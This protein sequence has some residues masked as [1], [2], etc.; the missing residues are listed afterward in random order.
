M[1]FA[2]FQRDSQGRFQATGDLPQWWQRLD[3][4]HD[5]SDD[6]MAFAERHPFFQHFLADA[7]SF[8][9]LGNPG[10]LDSGV[11]EHSLG[12]E[13]VLYLHLHAVQS[14]DG[15]QILI[16][17]DLE[18]TGLRY[19]AHVQRGR[20]SHLQYLKETNLR[21]QLEIE[22]QR[23]TEAAERLDRVRMEFLANVSHELRTPVSA[24]LGLSE[25]LDGT[26]LTSD[27]R[28]LV[29][30]L[31]S[32]GRQLLRLVQDLLDTSSM[33]SGQLVIRT[34]PYQLHEIVADAESS[35]RKRAEAKGL[36]FQIDI[37]ASLGE[38]GL[39]DVTRIRQIVNN[40]L[41][42]A[43][44]FTTTG[45]ITFR[46]GLTPL[47][48]RR[49]QLDVEDSGAGIP[50]DLQGTIFEPFV[51]V[52]ASMHRQHGGAGLG[53]A[54]SAQLAK[55]MGGTI[56]VQSQPGCGSRFSV[57]LPWEQPAVSLARHPHASV[58]SPT[59]RH[60]GAPLRQAEPTAL[61]L[62]VTAASSPRP[63]W[64]ILI[65]EDNPTNRLFLSRTLANEGHQVRECDGGAAV[66]R[67]WESE[68]F[69]V[70]LLDCQ[71][72]QV[73]GF[74]V[75]RHIR[76]AEQRE[77]GYLPIIAVTAHATL[78]DAARC[79]EAGMDSYLAKPFTVADL[80]EKLQAAVALGTPRNRLGTSNPTPKHSLIPDRQ[81]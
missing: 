13:L 7:K 64:N 55:A 5:G 2:V 28:E 17:Q 61:A 60:R 31:S 50:L 4:D 42:N 18:A 29:D 67:A 27:Q 11:W 72:P 76:E 58:S 46:V 36:A 12:N 51:Q 43:I 1:G 78:Q 40:L 10:R 32:S 35:F 24:M 39:G 21:A 59:A 44:K 80:L 53:L 9:D 8:W 81:S 6:P 30:G 63:I 62:D 54:I 22:L 77:G 19:Q 38:E 25:L 49:L 71:M 23:A 26:C 45:T 3:R 68:H 52:D 66:I 37:Q 41:D 14:L 74:D 73:T 47:P 70:L 56:R 33:E 15:S 75:A 79:R 20:E 16:V 69:D 57:E 65:A 34:A 48:P